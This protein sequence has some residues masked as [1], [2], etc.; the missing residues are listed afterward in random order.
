MTVSQR[1]R[2][3]L[4]AVDQLVREGTSATSRQVAIDVPDLS[5]GT[6]PVMLSLLVR[7]GLLSSSIQGPNSAGYTLTRAGRAA[8]EAP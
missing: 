3:L 7:R 6:V 1:T 4:A 5:P 8:L 2:V